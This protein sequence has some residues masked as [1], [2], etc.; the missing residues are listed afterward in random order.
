[1]LIYSYSMRLPYYVLRLS[2]FDLG[3]AKCSVAI[4][5]NNMFPVHSAHTEK[6]KIVEIDLFGF[7]C[8]DR[9][10]KSRRIYFVCNWMWC[11]LPNIV[12]KQNMAITSIYFKWN[13]HTGK[14]K[15]DKNKRDTNPSKWWEFKCSIWLHRWRDTNKKKMLNASLSIDFFSCLY[16]GRLENRYTEQN[17]AR[18]KN[19]LKDDPNGSSFLDIPPNEWL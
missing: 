4:E 10:T 3:C 11:V 2:S 9:T 12:T 7:L 15:S 8:T 6:I 1:M 19:K 18:K 13:E 14:Q 17:R 5:R 16:S